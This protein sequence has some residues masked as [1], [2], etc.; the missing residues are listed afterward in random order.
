MKQGA[1]GGH[2]VVMDPKLETLKRG[3][4]FSERRFGWRQPVFSVKSFG[5]EWQGVS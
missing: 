2:E 4:P 1:I 3:T 5:F